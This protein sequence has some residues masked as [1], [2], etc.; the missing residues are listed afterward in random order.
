LYSNAGLAP[1][2]HLKDGVEMSMKR[3]QLPA[4]FPYKGIRDL[5]QYIQDNAIEYQI[6]IEM[7]MPTKMN[8][9]DKAEGSYFHIE[10]TVL[11]RDEI[12]KV[13]PHAPE[14]Q[15]DPVKSLFE[16]HA[17]VPDHK[18]HLKAVFL[19]DGFYYFLQEIVEINQEL[20]RLVNIGCQKKLQELKGAKS[21]V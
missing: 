14:T 16:N 11:D 2:V 7:D 1:P 12:P 21:R 15:E 17:F 4:N 20:L 9:G 18:A 5:W 8:I 10:A 19:T 13:F 6:L 3:F